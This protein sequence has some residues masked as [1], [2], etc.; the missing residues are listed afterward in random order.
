MSNIPKMEQL[1]T[2]VKWQFTRNGSSTLG[3]SLSNAT[4]ASNTAV[5]MTGNVYRTPF[6][7][8]AMNGALWAYGHG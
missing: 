4:L 3:G 7:S 2:P 8:E 6:K 5:G 1:P